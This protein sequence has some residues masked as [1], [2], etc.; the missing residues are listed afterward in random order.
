MIGATGLGMGDVGPPKL[1]LDARAGM[2]LWKKSFEGV[3]PA[4]YELRVVTGGEDRV[5]MLVRL[6]ERKG[7]GSERICMLVGRRSAPVACACGG[8]GDTWLIA[9]GK[10]G[11]LGR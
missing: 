5:F 9:N 3:A 8:L 7:A 6:C 10:D 4:K 11:I 1:M 2:G